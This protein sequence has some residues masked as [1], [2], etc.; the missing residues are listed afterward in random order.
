[1]ARI[2]TW[3]KLIENEMERNNESFDDIEYC[4]L[5]PEELDKKF[6]AGFGCVDGEPFTVW[7]KNRVYFPTSYD[8]AEDCASVSKII[9]KNPTQHIGGW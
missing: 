9:D 3:K 1:M 4:T 2:N 7:T 8:G 5:S 6:D